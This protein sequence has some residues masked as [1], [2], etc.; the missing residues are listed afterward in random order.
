VRPEYSG[1]ILRG[2]KT[3]ELRRRVLRI[4]VGTR[5]WIYETVPGG[6][7]AAL[8]EIAAVAE[9]SPEDIWMRYGRQA[10]ITQEAFF[11]YFAGSHQ[12]CAVVLRKV[13]PLR[14]AL[15]LRELRASLGRFVAPQFYR[16]L[17]ENGAEIS[18]L[19]KFVPEV[20]F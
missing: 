18:L 3:V 7:V 1:R 12:S 9:G 4:P 10:A 20:G 17:P 6:C 19:R 8:A 15:A 14:R 13:I 11:A 5:V 2:E 16:K